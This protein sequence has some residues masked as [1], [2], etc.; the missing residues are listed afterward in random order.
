[1]FKR[2]LIANRGE[3]AVR[4]IRA[5][6]S[7]GIE[8]VAIYST[9][10][11]EALHV[12][13]STDSVCVGGPLPKD[14]YLNMENIISAATL[15]GCDAIHPGYG[16]LS[17]NAKFAR[18][19]EACNIAFI[20][21]SHEAI[22]IMGNKAKARNTMIE[23]GVPVVPGTG[24]INNADEGLNEAIRIGFPVLIKASAGGGGKGMRVANSIENFKQTFDMATNE[25][26]SAFGD[27]SVYLEKYI[28]NPK[29]IEFQL[30]GDTH[31]NV[32]HLFERDCSIQ[33]NH[34]KIIEEAPC[35]ALRED[36][37]QKMAEDVVK[38]AKAINYVNAG[39]FEFIMDKEQNYYFIEMNTR[40]QVE[41]PVTEMI[42]GIDLIKEQIR[43]AAGNPLSFTQE[44]V[45]VNGYSIECRINAED[46]KNNFR[47]SAGKI[48]N[49]ILPGG[50][51]IRVDTGLYS[52]F[53]VPPFY[54]SMVAKLIVSGKSRLE[55]IRKMRGALEEL[56]IE[57]IHT[58]IELHYAVFHN[59]KFVEGEFDTGFLAKFLEY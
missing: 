33:R 11:K 12:Q 29:H 52:G 35:R 22:D 16:F 26:I 28:E 7:L 48:E 27:G 41:H 34:Q 46:F 23:H 40:I 42:T 45:V 38:A 30:I 20:G 43:V 31:G 18:L 9:A 5:A 47:P 36:V 25:A 17:E 56:I 6:K 54:D 3:I 13:L 50:F 21:P 19:V 53:N 15:K 39:T 44:E 51:G 57:G 2:I 59:I 1:M 32:V 14:S 8:T 24:V 4:V 58:N 49:L 37:R 55:C 10:D